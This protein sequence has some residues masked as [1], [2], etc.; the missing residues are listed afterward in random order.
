[1][2]KNMKSVLIE[3]GVSLKIKNHSFAGFWAEE[4]KRPA[5]FSSVAVY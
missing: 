2:L 1:M 3:Y 4:F 5:V